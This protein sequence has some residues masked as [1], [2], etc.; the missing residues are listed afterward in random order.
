MGFFDLF[1]RKHSRAAQI[2]ERTLSDSERVGLV[3][4][5]LGA[6]LS[7]DSDPREIA[8]FGFC[9]AL[10]EQPFVPKFLASLPTDA[11]GQLP[12]PNKIESHILDL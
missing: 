7:K 11:A 2:P 12:P 8:A 9:G 6:P 5:A 4:E 10:L 3:I 1:R